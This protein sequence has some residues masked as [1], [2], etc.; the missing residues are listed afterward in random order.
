LDI[1]EEI[2]SIL[3]KSPSDQYAIYR[4]VGNVKMSQITKVIANLNHKQTID[5]VRYRKSRRTGFAIPVYGLSIQS[6]TKRGRRLNIDNLLAGVT[7]ER[8][9]EYSFLA[10]NL[11]NTYN[12]HTRIL[13]IGCGECLLTNT[14]AEFARN[15][16]RGRK[17]EVIGLDLD[18]CRR[19]EELDESSS[20]SLAQ[21]DARMLGFH[22]EIFDQIIC[23]STIEHIRVP[24]RGRN[25]VHP[26]DIGDLQAFCEIHRVLKKGG[27][28]ILTLPY[29]N[30]R[31]ENQEYRVYDTTA[32]KELIGSLSVI[33]KEFYRYNKGK[34][35][36]CADQSEA[37]RS[38]V[39]SFI[40]R[41]FH[42]YVCV[43]LLLRKE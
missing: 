12:K 20:M 10:R 3:E 15:K 25:M 2:I 43:C 32:L 39:M 5:V 30:R 37:D 40:P 27:T 36:K 24:F 13:D 35:K 19:K 29:L 38:A 26:D 21:M 6:P 34:W 9:V 23:I 14:I 16:N 17:W 11:I 33:K 22:E 28:I 8:L 42:S 41:Y 18:L 7:S 31:T 4:K 1:E